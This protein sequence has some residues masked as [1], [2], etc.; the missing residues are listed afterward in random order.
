MNRDSSKAHPLKG[1]QLSGVPPVVAASEIAP[2]SVT[3]ASGKFHL[4]RWLA[5]GLSGSFMELN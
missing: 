5:G 3:G 2:K 1:R 4:A